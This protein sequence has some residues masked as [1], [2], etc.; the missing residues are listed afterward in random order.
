MMLEESQSLDVAMKEPKVILISSN[1]DKFTL[2]KRDAMISKYI[3]NSLQQHYNENETAEIPCLQVST[4]CL[5]FIVEYMM[6]HEGVEH[7]KFEGKCTDSDI[8]K[9]PGIDS[10]DAQFIKNVCGCGMQTMYDFFCAADYFIIPNLVQ[11]CGLQIT[12]CIYNKNLE[13]ITQALKV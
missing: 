1:K 5:N 12:C 13:Q 11:L 2:L 4:V 7:P 8:A 10:W 3:K 6:H 9:I